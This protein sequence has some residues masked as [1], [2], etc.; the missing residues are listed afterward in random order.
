MC[1]CI[2]YKNI[3]VV[4]QSN[5]FN[6]TDSCKFTER[7]IYSPDKGPNK[8]DQKSCKCRQNKYRPISLGHFTYHIINLLVILHSDPILMTTGYARIKPHF[9]ATTCSPEIQFL[10]YILLS[11]KSIFCLPAINKCADYAVPI[12]CSCCICSKC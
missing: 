8:S 6:V 7:K 1:K 4:G 12:T 3:F 2:I 10:F 9:R 11:R 5:K